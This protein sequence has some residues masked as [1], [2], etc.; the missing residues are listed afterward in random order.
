VLPP[1]RQLLLLCHNG[2]KAARALFSAAGGMV[3]EQGGISSRRSPYELEYCRSL[4]SETELGYL[5]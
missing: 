4:I 1:A 3:D 2:P 5:V